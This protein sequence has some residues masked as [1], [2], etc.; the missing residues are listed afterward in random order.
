MRDFLPNCGEKIRSN[1]RLGFPSDGILEYAWIS[2]GL[3]R[4]QGLFYQRVADAHLRSER[5]PLISGSGKILHSGV[6]F[7]TSA[8]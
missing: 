4:E 8:H 2:H 3:P 5:P 1:N 7:L 6:F